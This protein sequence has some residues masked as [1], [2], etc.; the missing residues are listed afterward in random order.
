MRPWKQS[1]ASLRPDPATS[2]AQVNCES[3]SLG[4]ARATDTQPLP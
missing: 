1:R 4:R 2:E 3:G